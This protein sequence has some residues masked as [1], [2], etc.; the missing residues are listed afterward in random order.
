MIWSAGRE[1]RR[2]RRH[3]CYLY[4]N[5]RHAHVSYRGESVDAKDIKYWLYPEF[6]S[7]VKA[8][9]I[10]GH[11]QS[12]VE[13]ITPDTVTLAPTDGDGPREELPIDFVLAMTGYQADLSL[14]TAVSVTLQGAQNAPVFNSDTMET[15]I[16]GLYIAGTA[17]A[18][19]QR[20]YRVFLENCHVHVDR[21]LAHLTG[22]VA[23]EQAAPAEVIE[24]PES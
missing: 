10:V 15:N 5:C 19:T 18:G 9:K 13:R 22:K 23:P 16:P 3:C 14:A 8:G 1:I 17:I 21:I 24:R 6:S 12:V 11:F 7:L 20:R 2:W 4:R